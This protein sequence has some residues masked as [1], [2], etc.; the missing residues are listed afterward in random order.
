MPQ[1]GV[2]SP[3]AKVLISVFLLPCPRALAHFSLSPSSCFRTL[4]SSILH[5]YPDQWSYIKVS[6]ASLQKDWP[7]ARALLLVILPSCS[8]SIGSWVTLNQVFKKLDGEL[9]GKPTFHCPR[10]LDLKLDWWQA[11]ALHKATCTDILVFQI[12][13]TKMTWR[14]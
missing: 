14:G 9:C 8:C 11:C 7:L 1:C 4:L 10:S 13:H 12:L 3:L 6:R 5:M 2:S